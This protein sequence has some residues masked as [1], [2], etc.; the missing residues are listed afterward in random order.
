MKILTVKKLLIPAVMATL[1]VGCASLQKPQTLLDAEQAYKVAASDSSVQKYAAAELNKANKTLKSAAVAETA[2]DMASLAYIGNAEVGTAVN[3][4]AAEISRQNSIDLLAKKEQ[5]ISDSLNLKKD[6]TQSKLLQMQLTEAE[7]E[8]LLAFGDIEFV[9][10]TADLVPGASV[11]IDL[12]AAYMQKYPSKKVTLE[13]HTDNTGSTKLNNE[14]SQ[15][16]ADFIRSVLMTKGVAANRIT[17]IGYG[18]SQPVASN[19]SSAGRQ[20]N[21]RIDIKFK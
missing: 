8:I 2:E 20:K 19:S 9:T 3:T 4:A 7:R 16:R 6:A 10:G 21:R 11:G 5:L 13:G 17:A 14:L 1:A 12:L 18:Q 15:K